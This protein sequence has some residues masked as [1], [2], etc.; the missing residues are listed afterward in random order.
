MGKSQYGSD[1]PLAPCGKI[2][3]DL[4]EE[5][6]KKWLEALIRRLEACKPGESYTLDPVERMLV[7]DALNARPQERSP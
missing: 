4:Q 3:M 2:S 5:H 6:R 7:L 1:L